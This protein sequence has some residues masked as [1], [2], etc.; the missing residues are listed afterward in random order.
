MALKRFD[1]EFVEAILKEPETAIEKLDLIYVDSS[2]LAIERLKKGDQ[3]LYVL[4]GRPLSETKQIKRIEDLVIPP[5]WKGV[6]IADLDNAHLQAVGNDLRKRKQYKYHPLWTKVRNQTKFYKMTVFGQQLPKIRERVEQ[7]LDQEGWPK[8]KVLALIIRLMEETHIRIGNE[9]YAKKNKTYGL[10]TLRSKHV[11]SLKDK[12]RF[13][14]TGK[15]G[16]KHKITLRNKKL[17]RLV[18]RCEEIPGWELFKF[19]DKDGEKQTVDSGMVNEY[20]HQISGEL[21]TAKDFRTWAA[22]IVF[23]NS[24]MDMDT[25][26]DEKELAKNILGAYDI[27]AKELG[28]TRN[29][30]RQYYVHPLLPKYYELGKLKGYFNKV[31]TVEPIENLSPAETVVLELLADYKPA[32]ELEAM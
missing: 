20:I 5:A 11:T 4:N 2:K 7:D 9:Q 12:V 17:V 28:N 15:R 1:T 18:N 29:V 30:C 25:A 32:F 21:F 13:E 26:T 19:F 14:F 23:F 10:S 16:K 24:L 8:T 27:T 31:D 3:F 22:S 6:K